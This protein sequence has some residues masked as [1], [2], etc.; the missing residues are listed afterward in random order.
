MKYIG[1]G[2]KMK[3]THI[4]DLID[5][6]I[7][8]KRQLR[9]QKMD[10]LKGMISFL[11]SMMPALEKIKGQYSLQEHLRQLKRELDKYLNLEQ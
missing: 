3:L 9:K 7:A 11:E 2:V 8:L 10:S 6:N 4:G 1:V 5:E